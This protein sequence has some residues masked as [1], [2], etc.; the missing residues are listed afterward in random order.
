MFTQSTEDHVVYIF[1]VHGL[2]IF[3]G[4]AV[5]VENAPASQPIARKIVEKRVLFVVNIDCVRRGA[6]N[7]ARCQE[8]VAAAGT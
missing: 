2:P 1:P 7:S 5:L 8:S 6:L 4:Y 3:M